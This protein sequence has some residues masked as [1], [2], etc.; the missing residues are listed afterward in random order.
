VAFLFSWW[1]FIFF[2]QALSSAIISSWA[3][4]ILAWLVSNL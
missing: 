2:R 1:A 4:S 3:A